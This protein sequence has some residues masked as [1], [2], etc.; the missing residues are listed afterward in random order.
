MKDQEFIELL[1]LYLDHEITPA[2]AKRLEVEV[3]SNPE[4]HRVYR[5]Y[6]QL[7]KGCGVLAAQFVSERAANPNLAARRRS[8]NRTVIIAFGSF[9]AVAACVALVLF[10]GGRRKVSPSQ[11][12]DAVASVSKPTTGSAHHPGVVLASGS[13]FGAK[14]PLARESA[15]S[16]ASDGLEWVRSFQVNA[17]PN[18]AEPTRFEPAPDLFRHDLRAVP[19][20][21]NQAPAAES[22]AFRLQR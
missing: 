13:G 18:L 3:R 11:P 14:G 19:A 7:H 10:F 21:P 4:R 8:S 5:E 15:N 22:A 20:T 2:D 9:A 6:C 12:A 17:T 1:N 16:L